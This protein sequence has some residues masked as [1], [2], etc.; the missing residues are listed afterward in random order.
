MKSDSAIKK[1]LTGAVLAYAVLA[2]CYTLK[3]FDLGWQLAAGRYIFEAGHLP[4]HDV[5]SYTAAGKEFIYPAG[6][7]LLFFL[8]YRAGGYA[9]LNLLGMAVCACTVALVLYGGAAQGRQAT[10]GWSFEP[11]T[12]SLWLAALA[13]PLIAERTGARAEM[14]TT[15]LFTAVLVILLQFERGLDRPLCLLPLLFAVW[16]NLHQG[17]AFGLAV[18]AA[19]LAVRGVRCVRG[20]EGGAALRR[21]LIFCSLSA[22]AVLLNPWGWRLYA[23]LW[24]VRQDQAFQRGLIVEASGVAWGWWRLNEVFRLDDPDAGI[25]LLLIAALVGTAIA[26]F[27]RQLLPA[28]LLAGTCWLGLHYS[29]GRVLTAITVAILLPSLAETALPKIETRKGDHPQRRSPGTGGPFRALAKSRVAKFVTPAATA[30]LALLLVAR[31]ADLLTSR[32]YIT[33]GDYATFGLGLSWWFP[34]RALDFIERERL[35]GR[36]YHDYN[37]GGWVMWRLWP[38]Y[39]VYIDGRAQ[40][41]T[42]EV[43]LE[44]YALH[45]W[46]PGSPEWRDFLDRRGINTILVS[47]ARYGGYRVDPSGLC[48]SPDFRLVY[49]D[50][51]SGVWLRARPENKAW[52]DR[53]GI[54]CPP[55]PFPV[56]GSS[57]AER[58]NFLANAGRLYRAFGMDAQALECYQQAEHLFPDDPNLRVGFAQ[59]W[60]RRG[61]PAEAHR[62]YLN[63]L[64]LR[65]SAPV[66]EALGTLAAREGRHAEAADDFARAAERTVLPQEDYRLLGEA[67]LRLNQPGRALEAFGKA[68]KTN[69]F[70]GERAWVSR[71]WLEQVEDGERRAREMTRQAQ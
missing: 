63:S 43:M 67:C 52:L 39:Q 7:E 22:A 64:A 14:F 56:A 70:Q 37:L 11:R 44:D 23:S 21:L 49:I 18:M 61:R 55:A 68:R 2:S 15:V 30:L 47:L 48:A 35:P 51:V 42:P 53:L 33:H 12:L 38:R 1:T 19:A 27:R 50:E 65:D 46:E 45:A 16:A 59:L 36:I 26:L 5:F 34:E 32:Y 69:R 10:K 62:E 4:R 17:F 20:R 31:S 9:A 58:Y 6:A 54:A 60:L 71:R 57:P 25:W 8:L 13:V 40:P 29:R 41:F 3:N 28:A 24:R 66:W